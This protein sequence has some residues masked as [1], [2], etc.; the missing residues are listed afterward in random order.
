MSAETSFFTVGGIGSAAEETRNAAYESR[1]YSGSELEDIRVEG[2]VRNAI[3]H[4]LW[5]FYEHEPAFS[6]NWHFTALF[7]NRA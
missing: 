4:S 6:P 7:R 2:R 1:R 3:F 5:Y